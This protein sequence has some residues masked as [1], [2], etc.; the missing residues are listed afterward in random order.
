MTTLTA[1]F[2]STFDY[3]LSFV[4]AIVM[5]AAVSDKARAQTI[6][7]TLLDI[8]RR[9]AHAVYQAAGRERSD[10]LAALLEDVRIFAARHENSAEAVAWHGIIAR[11]CIKTRRNGR[12]A[13]LRRE[14]HNALVKA[15]SLD[16]LVLDGLVYANLGALYAQTPS[17]FGGFGSKVRG[18]GYMWRAIVV[19][20]DG[21][22]ANYLY[23]EL[24]VDENK[25]AEARDILVKASKTPARPDHLQSD[26]GRRQ[27]ILSLLEK[28]ESRMGKST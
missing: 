20:P 8:E 14:A 6:D 13:S 18:I 10:A 12:S 15:E 22:D 5:S 11:E 4:M 7:E 21:L 16:P 26:Q 27:Q 23:A 17:G 3:I 28:V 24:L 2:G 19:D 9:W 25:L 1:R